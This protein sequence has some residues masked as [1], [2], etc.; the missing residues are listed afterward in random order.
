MKVSP[1]T[2][3]SATAL[4]NIPARPLPTNSD[5][6]PQP[7]PGNPD[8]LFTPAVGRTLARALLETRAE[9]DRYRK[10][11][12]ETLAALTAEQQAHRRTR[13]NLLQALRDALP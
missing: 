4:T 7:T 10:L 6:S 9:R 13:N 12:E 3:E 2:P 11:Y 5:T 8:E 1:Q